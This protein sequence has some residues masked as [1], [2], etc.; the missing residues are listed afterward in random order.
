VYVCGAPTRMRNM[1][2]IGHILSTD[3]QQ[4]ALLGSARGS[5]IISGC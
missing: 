4:G 3:C 2:K 5:S 1:K